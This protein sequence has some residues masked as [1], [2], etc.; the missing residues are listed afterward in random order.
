M[1]V[2]MPA[3][4]RKG[5]YQDALGCRPGRVP[6]GGTPEKRRRRKKC[7]IYAQLYAWKPSNELKRCPNLE[8]AC[9]KM[10]WDVALGGPSEARKLRYMREYTPE[11]QVTNCV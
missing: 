6:P 8:K 4:P 11:N 10:P 9:I 7:D 1:Y 2:I 5:V 3:E